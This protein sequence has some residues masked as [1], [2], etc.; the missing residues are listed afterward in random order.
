MHEKA[1]VLQAPQKLVIELDMDV[2][3]ILTQS[4]AV[5]I[6]DGPYIL[7]TMTGQVFAVSKLFEDKYQA[8]IGGSF[9]P[10]S[11]SVFFEWMHGEVSP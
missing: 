7:Q 4:A 3:T 2:V 9:R 11:S 8:F 5:C 10:D 1:I 6:P